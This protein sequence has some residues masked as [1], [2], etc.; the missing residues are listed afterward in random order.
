MALAIGLGTVGTPG[1]PSG[2]AAAAVSC[3]GTGTTATKDVRYK[4]VSGVDPDLLS[5]D[6]YVPTRSA[7]CGPAPLVVYVHGGGFRRGDKANKVDDKVELFNNEGWVFA[8]V[9][10]RLSP[11]ST[12]D[13]SRVRY[14]THEQDVAAALAWLK[15]HASALGADPHRILLM[16]HSSGAFIASLVSTDTSFLTGAGVSAGDVSCTASLDTEYDVANQIAQ[17]GTQEALYRNAFGSDPAVWSNGSPV[18]HTAGGQARPSFLIFTRGAAR[19]IADA[20]DFNAALI[21]GG[22]PSSIIDVSPLDHESVNEAVGRA[23]DTKVT[24]PLMDFFRSC[25]SPTATTDRSWVRAVYEDVLGRA[26]SDVELDATVARL[27]GGS[28]RTTVATELTSSSEWASHIVIGFY[29]DTLDRPPDASGLGY[30]T[31]Q[32][33]ARR[34][35]VAQVAVQFYASAEYFD[36]IGGGTDTSWVSDLYA[37]LLDRDADPSGL[38]YWT[39]RSRDRGR[40]DVAGAFYASLESRR[41]R[42]DSL[43]LALLGRHADAAG[44]SYWAARLG[45]EDDLTL[46]VHLITSAEYDRRATTRHPAG[47]S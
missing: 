18:N 6:H 25:A 41:Q 24:P 13:P 31:D 17:G 20:R 46:A 11:S 2:P 27:G 22:T 33:R 5:L 30:W 36:G 21:A 32:I 26:P 23:G 8:S 42:V 1:A 7:G 35:T 16:G 14:P 15:D 3:R 43:Y 38:A 45:R 40:A 12:S 47:T 39:D 34:R 10:Y 28:S 37:K 44:L 9:N 4:Q 29:Q 19:R